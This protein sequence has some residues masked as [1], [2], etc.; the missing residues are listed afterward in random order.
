M[1]TYT[2]ECKKCGT[3]MELFHSMSATPKVQCE[4]CGS[5]SVQKLLGT[6][7]GIIFKG[8]GFYETDYKSKKG[9]AKPA[10]ESKPASKSETKSG[11]KKDSKSNSSAA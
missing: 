3:Q 9:D 7:A 10:K 11:G 5:R 6:G 1:P 4:E 2:Y 8:S